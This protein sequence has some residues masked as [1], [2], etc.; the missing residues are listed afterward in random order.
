MQKTFLLWMFLFF[1]MTTLTA[2]QQQEPSLVET[3]EAQD[4]LIKKELDRFFD[5]QLL[6]ERFAEK[7]QE[8][9]I[10]NLLLMIDDKNLYN[11]KIAAAV[12]VFRQKYAK[13]VVQRDKVLIEKA[14]LRRLEVSKSIFLEIEIM[15]TLLLMDRYRFFTEM[16]S[17]LIKGLDH[18]DLSAV[19][20]AYKALNEVVLME[21]P[22]RVR[23]ARIVFNILRKIFFLSRKKLVNADIQDTR[24]KYK[25]SLLRWAIKVL[26]TQE[27]KNLPKEVISLM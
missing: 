11:Y 12:R 3:V 7:I 17:M 27:L 6:I 9:T 21:K 5:D 25:L 15:H 14:F 20:L 19:D 18:Y 8:E 10:E 2:A 24:L 22:S 23:E 4:D 16:T 13:E 1:S 26:G